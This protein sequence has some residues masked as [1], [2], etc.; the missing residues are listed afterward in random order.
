MKT[1]ISLILTLISLF[2]FSQTPTRE[3]TRLQKSQIE[4]GYGMFI[5]FGINTFNEIEWS[6]GNL[7][8]TSYNPTNLDCDQWIKVAKEAGFRYVILITKHHDGFC[9][10]DSKPFVNLQTRN[11]PAV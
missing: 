2:V 3:M 1:V 7:P 11:A 4:R 6:K 9:L 5:H 8:A 10:W